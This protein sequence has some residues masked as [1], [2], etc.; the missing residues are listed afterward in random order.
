MTQA[1]TCEVG[2]IRGPRSGEATKARTVPPR[3]PDGTQ[4][5]L[6]G[7]AVLVAINFISTKADTGSLAAFHL[8]VADDGVASAA[9]DTAGVLVHLTG[10]IVGLDSRVHRALFYAHA[11]ARLFSSLRSCI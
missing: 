2:C 5:Y 10:T 7:D 1:S 8:V 3:F 9:V 4:S 6:A 11:L